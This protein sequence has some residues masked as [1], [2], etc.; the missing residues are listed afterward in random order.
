MSGLQQISGSQGVQ[1]SGSARGERVHRTVSRIE[2]ALLVGG[3]VAL[4]A[5]LAP[6]V[7]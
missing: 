7:Q 4:I 6:F 5:A 2:L 1:S 3:V